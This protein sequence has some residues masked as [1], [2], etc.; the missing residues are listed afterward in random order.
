MHKY[1][2]AHWCGEHGLLRSCLL[3]GGI[4]FF[5]SAIGWAL[6]GCLLLIPV[7]A[8]V[9]F[10]FGVRTETCTWIATY[11]LCYTSL[12]GGLL[13]AIWASVGIFRCGVRNAFDKTNTKARRI[14]GVVAIAWAL[15]ITVPMVTH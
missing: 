4:L 8:I 2:L 10:A 9:H 5:V 14:G 15:W 6:L 11:I 13:W 12:A 1:V 3:N 7:F